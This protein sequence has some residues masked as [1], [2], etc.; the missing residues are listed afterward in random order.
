MNQFE[1]LCTFYASI[2]VD[3]K[4]NVVNTCVN[5]FEIEINDKGNEE[6]E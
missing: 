2:C 4:C 3:S 6:E 1:D 5:Y